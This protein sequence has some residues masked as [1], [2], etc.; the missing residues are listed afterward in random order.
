MKGVIV[1]IA[2]LS[3]LLLSV[4]ISGCSDQG[5]EGTETVQPTVAKTTETPLPTV[6]AEI[7]GE[8]K[9]EMTPWTPDGV[10]TEGEYKEVFR[11]D[12]G[13]FEFYWRNDDEKL[14]AGMSG[15]SEGWV[16]VG[17]SP[18]SVMKDADIILGYIEDS[19]LNIHDMYSI[20]I[21]GPHPDDTDMGG[22]YSIL[23]SGGMEKDGKTTVEFSRYLDTGDSYDSKLSKGTDVKFLWSVAERDDPEFKHNVAKGSSS[24]RLS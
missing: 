8:D 11:S 12:D 1:I 5:S 23:S 9:E 18:T 7:P 22:E 17:F 13:K 16:S 20:G 15:N 19:V 21:Y 3:L 6:M 24:F 14:Y 2:F 10:I 4:C